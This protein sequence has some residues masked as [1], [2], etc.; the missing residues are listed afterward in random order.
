MNRRHESAVSGLRG[1]LA[2]IRLDGESNWPAIVE[3]LGRAL[4]AGLAGVYG[5]RRVG[6]AL[7]PGLVHIGGVGAVAATE[8]VRGLIGHRALTY[9]PLNVLPDDQNRVTTLDELVQLG[10]ATPVTLEAL[11]QFGRQ[12]ADVSVAAQVR[13]LISEGK[14]LLG[15]VGGV[16]EDPDAFGADEKALLRALVPALRHRLVLEERLAQAPLRSATLDATLEALTEPAFVV[17][18]AGMPVL[19]NAA[20]LA[21]WET[22]RLDVETQLADAVRGDGAHFRRSAITGNGV[23]QHWLLVRH[24]SASREVELRHAH[25]VQ[26]WGLTPREG[27]VLRLVADGRTNH[28]I[29]R[30]L[31][32][33]ERTTEL[34]VSRLLQKAGVSNRASLVALFWTGRRTD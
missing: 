2:T 18:A 10:R 15:W 27:D 8:Y 17:T 9:D 7:G 25:S 12:L 19:M 22:S 21:L 4:G 13:A 16:D 28:A 5:F 14:T 32:C 20:G 26:A 29:S 3:Q 24:A 34:H 30:E 33:A 23:P 1:E 6:A 11:R 31:G